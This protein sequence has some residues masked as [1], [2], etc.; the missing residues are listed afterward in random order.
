MGPADSRVDPGALARALLVPA[1]YP[2]AVVLAHAI[3]S[4]GF[5]AYDRIGWI[6]IPV[7][8]LG[9]AAIGYFFSAVLIG[10]ARLGLLRASDAMTHALLVLGLVALAAIGWEFLEFI[11][12]SVLGTNV[13]R[14]IANVMRDQLAGLAGG[15]CLVLVRTSY[16][17]RT[18]KP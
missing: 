16:L 1:I 3:L 12:D 8:V 6:D 11:Y 15:L 9:G 14:S 17:M 7:H 5:D 4:R 18:G 10:L 2:L 13:Q